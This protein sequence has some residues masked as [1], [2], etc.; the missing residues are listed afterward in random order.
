MLGSKTFISAIPVEKFATGALVRIIK[1]HWC[2]GTGQR[3][4]GRLCTYLL[5]NAAFHDR[6]EKWSSMCL[7]PLVRFIHG[8][9]ILILYVPELVPSPE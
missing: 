5:Y 8:R 6:L 7:G 3:D 9:S 1:K 4:L 2:I